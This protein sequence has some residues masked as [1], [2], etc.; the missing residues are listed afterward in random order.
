MAD[1]QA[2]RKNTERR[3]VQRENHRS[4]LETVARR[5]GLESNLKRIPRLFFA[6][7]VG[8]VLLWASSCEML[9]V[10]RAALGPHRDVDKETYN[11]KSFCDHYTRSIY[12]YLSECIFY[13]NVPAWNKGTRYISA[14]RI[15]KTER[16]KV[17]LDN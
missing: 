16:T 1:F 7:A 5:G 3:R 4:V 13:G 12:I 10:S 9:C 14:R 11:G 2:R 17:E 15:M 6:D 8:S